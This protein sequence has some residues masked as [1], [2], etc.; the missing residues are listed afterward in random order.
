MAEKITFYFSFLGYFI[1]CIYSRLLHGISYETS[2]IQDLAVYAAYLG[3][4]C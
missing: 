2:K 3:W 1:L 4:E